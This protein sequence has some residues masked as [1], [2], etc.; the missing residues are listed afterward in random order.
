[1]LT[2]VFISSSDNQASFMALKPFN[3]VVNLNIEWVLT[4]TKKLML[5]LLKVIKVRKCPKNRYTCNNLG[6]K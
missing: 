3:F 6:M 4:F 5:N 1:M 2:S